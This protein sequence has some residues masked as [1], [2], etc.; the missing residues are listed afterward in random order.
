MRRTRKSATKGATHSVPATSALRS[1]LTTIHE[2][3]PARAARIP[4]PLGR[5]LC[6][7][8]PRRSCWVPPLAP[9]GCGLQ[10]TFLQTT[11][12]RSTW[13][14]PLNF[15]QALQPKTGSIPCSMAA[16]GTWGRTCHVRG[17]LAQVQRL[18]PGPAPESEQR[19][20]EAEGG[21]QVLQRLR[22]PLRHRLPPR[23]PPLRPSCTTLPRD[24]ARVATF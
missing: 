12:P 17:G 15:R 21:T 16:V 2:C 13:Q 23:P 5:P 22:R 18:K 7:L 3:S 24:A 6:R 4:T 20:G 14:P 11:S 19:V 8:A 1:G 9:P 10:D